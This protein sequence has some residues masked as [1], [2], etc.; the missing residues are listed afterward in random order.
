MA[1]FITASEIKAY[2]LPVTTNQWGKVGD[3]QLDVVIGYASE[4]LEDYLDREILEATY[5]ERHRKGT[6]T[7]TRMLGLFPAT[8]LNSVKSYTGKTVETIW[9]VDLFLLPSN[10]ILEFLDRDTYAFTALN[11][12]VINYDAGYAAVPGPLKHAVMLQTVKFLQ[13]LFRGGTAFSETDLI[14]E[15]DEEVVELLEP[16]KR[17]RLS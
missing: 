15:L 8:T 16:Y 7:N 17:R 13:P 9:D 11:T 2:P 3:D 14:D 10:G 4:H 12:W 5:D 6:G 1:N